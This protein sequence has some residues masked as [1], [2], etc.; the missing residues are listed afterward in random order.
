MEGGKAFVVGVTE[1]GGKFY[2]DRVYTMKGIPKQ[3]LGLTNIT[4]SADTMGDL[5]VQWTFKIN[6]SAYV[7][8]GFDER[9]DPPEDRKQNPKKWFSNG[10]TKTGGSVVL[11]SPS[12]MDYWIYKSNEPYPK[13]KV[14]LDGISQGGGDGTYRVIFVKQTN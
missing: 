7:Y 4:A 13:G 2:H 8:I 3:Y 5:D 1:E 14:T 9:W 10:F 12:P 6:L 11:R